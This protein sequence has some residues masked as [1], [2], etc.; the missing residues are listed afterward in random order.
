LNPRKILLIL[1]KY[2]FIPK[3]EKGT[4]S[5]SK[6]PGKLLSLN[7]TKLSPKSFCNV[8]LIVLIFVISLK[9]QSW[10]FD[11]ITP[12]VY[13][14]NKNDFRIGFVYF[15]DKT[16]NILTYSFAGT[17]LANII[18]TYICIWMNTTSGA[19]NL[20]FTNKLSDTFSSFIPPKPTKLHSP[21]IFISP[22][23]KV[24]SLVT[25]LLP[26][27]A[28]FTISKLWVFEKVFWS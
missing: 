24:F 5:L 25:K 15:T 27:T 21:G 3:G 4:K 16:L 8:L 10:C 19:Y 12:L 18:G 13:F 6:S 17:V 23:Q 11:E 2:V 28:N 9:C 22:V 26:N 20:S 14:C 7:F 1:K